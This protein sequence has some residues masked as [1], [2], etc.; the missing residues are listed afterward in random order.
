MYRGDVGS[1]IAWLFGVVLGYFPFIIPGLVLH[2][3][4]IVAAAAKPSQGAATAPSAQRQVAAVL[5]PERRARQGRVFR[6]VVIAWVGFLALVGLGVWV[7]QIVEE[8]EKA[9][10]EAAWRESHK[11]DAAKTATPAAPDDGRL[12]PRDL[13]SFLQ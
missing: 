6:N 2:V 10:L 7:T 9:R 8:R 1:G 5:T 12:G 13:A 3:L 4:C 11:D